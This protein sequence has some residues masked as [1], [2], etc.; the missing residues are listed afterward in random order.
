MG[1]RELF[2]LVMRVKKKD[3]DKNIQKLL[4]EMENKKNRT[5]YFRTVI[6]LFFKKEKY[7]FEGKIKG[8]ILYAPLGTNGFGYDSI[9]QPDG[10]TRSF[11]Q[12]TLKEKNE[13]SHRFLA[14]KKIL[15]FFKKKK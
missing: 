8:S 10:Y 2:L 12:F 14:L 6:A 4:S 3:D 7:F 11:G 13:I 5:A 1:C 9:F 15:K